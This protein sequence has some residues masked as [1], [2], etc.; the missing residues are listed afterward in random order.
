MDVHFTYNGDCHVELSLEMPS[1][2]A[3]V[4]S[5][6]KNVFFEGTL[7]IQMNPLIKSPP[8]I[9]GVKISLLSHPNLDFELGGVAG[10]LEL[11]LLRQIVRYILLDQIER[12]LLLPNNQ[13]FS[14][15]ED[16]SMFCEMART[17]DEPEGVLCI[18]LVEAEN[19]VN[20]DSEILGQGVSDP[21]T[22]IDFT[23]Q[24]PF[25]YARTY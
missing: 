2:A 17:V 7:R 14:I 24:R 18:T 6:L 21:Y 4:V 13:Y 5:S 1:P 22:I 9:G 8:L 15:S 16:V 19:L 25:K 10:I 20:K 3:P 12:A 11:P 23:N